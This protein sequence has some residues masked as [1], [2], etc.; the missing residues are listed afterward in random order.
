MPRVIA[1]RRFVLFLGALSLGACA[2]DTERAGSGAAGVG[3]APSGGGSGGAAS[4]AGAAGGVGGA[5]AGGTAGVGE[6]GSGGE[7]PPREPCVTAPAARYPSGSVLT[8]AVRPQLQ[9]RPLVLGEE[10]AA[11]P[12][13]RVL[14]LTAL[15]FYLSGLTLVDDTGQD[16]PVD[17]VDA[18]GKLVP[19]GVQLVDLEA[20][21]SA[22]LRLRAPAGRYRALRAAL[23]LPVGCNVISPV[24][25]VYPLN[26]AAGMTWLWALG[27]I[28][29]RIEGKQKA[30]ASATA[31][32]PVSAHA[33]ALP[34]N[35]PP[36]I[37]ASPLDFELP[38]GGTAGT[39]TFT[40]DSVM[41]LV[42]GPDDFATG[43]AVMDSIRANPEGLARFTRP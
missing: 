12:E 10:T 26:A 9:G 3:G 21:A 29:L 6:G 11:L 8:V 27:Y 31:W 4:S 2:G 14:L 39:L 22:T 20:P 13:G 28:H 42:K 25:A 37:F 17:V 30:G 7:A 18:A 33:G 38:A 40:L 35:T 5:G 23:G 34:P 32:S 19:Y 1:F 41:A 16:V 43:Q 15:R 36:P 24:D